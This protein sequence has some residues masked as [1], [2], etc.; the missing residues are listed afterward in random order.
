MPQ[1]MQVTAP[2]RTRDE[3]EA[4]CVR[5]VRAELVSISGALILSTCIML[6]ILLYIGW[7]IPTI[8]RTQLAILAFL[9]AISWMYLADSATERFCLVDRSILFTSLLTKDRTIK[10]S[11]LDSLLYVHNGFN[12]ERGIDSVEFRRRGKR[13][14]RVAL[15]P[16]WQRHKLEDFLHSVEQALQDPK[17]LEEVR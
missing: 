8:S 16:C 13:P 3:R 4:A 7:Q 5:E 12:L 14:D 11:D 9:V 10:L 17:I 1:V 6:T 15:G 2:A